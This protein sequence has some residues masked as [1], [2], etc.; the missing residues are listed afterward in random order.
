MFQGFNNV[1]D[2]IWRNILIYMNK[3]TTVSYCLHRLWQTKEMFHSIPDTVIVVLAY[4]Y[5]H[6][7]LSHLQPLSK[8]AFHHKGGENLMRIEVIP[9]AEHDVHCAF[10]EGIETRIDKILISGKNTLL[11]QH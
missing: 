1:F 8:L 10:L 2:A 6:R 3:Y 9:L 11:R 5:F 7:D 4:I